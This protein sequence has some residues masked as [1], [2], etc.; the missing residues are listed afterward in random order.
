MGLLCQLLGSLWLA[1]LL[2]TPVLRSEELSSG[3]SFGFSGHTGPLDLSTTTAGSSHH[4]SAW[5]ESGY[6]LFCLCMGRM[7]NQIAHFL[8]GMATAKAINRTLIL[9]PFRTFRN[10]AF[11]EWY[12]P[13]AVAEFHRV[14]TVDEFFRRFAARWPPSKRVAMCFNFPGA[15]TPCKIEGNPFENFWNELDV[16]FARTENFYLPL[17]VYGDRQRA[18]WTERFPPKDYPVLALRGAPA[19]YPIKREHNE[20]HRH[21]RW[22]KAVAAERDRLIEAHLLKP[23]V[24]IHIRNAVD[25]DRACTRLDQMRPGRFMASAQCLGYG[26]E[27]GTLT[28]D[29]CYPPP[30]EIVQR[31]ARAVRKLKA[32]AIFVATADNPMVKELQ[33]AVGKKVK[34][35]HLDAQPHIDMAILAQADHFIG[36]CVSSFSAA[37]RQE[38]DVH[39]KSSSFFSFPSVLK[40]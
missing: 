4:G 17:D 3:N 1:F 8:G 10:V 33:K 31:T 28:R 21:L 30:E 9:P 23:F 6:I 7:G 39:G 25:F 5:D 37:V 2:T 18:E 16:H 35:V 26:S 15:S 40:K 22:S 11:E 36:N 20:L 34:V 29:L 24:G 38:R 14:I 27:H 19:S 13:A 32:V 12:D